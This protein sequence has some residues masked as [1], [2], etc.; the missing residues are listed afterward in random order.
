MK[1][2][3]SLLLALVLTLSV[4]SVAF[5]NETKKVTISIL[6]HWNTYNHALD[7]SDAPDYMKDYYD[8]IRHELLPGYEIEIEWILYEDDT[9]QIPLLLA[10]GDVP[11]IFVSD[12]TKFME[13]LDTG[14]FIEDLTPYLEQYGQNIL[15]NT[16]ARSRKI[17]TVGGKL[18]AIPSENFYYKFRTIIRTDWVEAL[19]FDVKKVYTLS[20]IKDIMLA[21]TNQDPDK[22]GKNDTFGLGTRYNGG[23]WPQSFMPIFGAFNGSI[24]DFYINEDN[25]V[26]SYN[27]S[28]DFRA[29]LSFLTEMYA[30]GAID[31]EVFVLNYD[32]AR[33][34]AAQGKGGMFSGWWNVVG[35][36]LDAGLLELQPEARLDFIYITS[37]DGKYEGNKDNGTIWK[38][39]M[40]S[41]D[42]EAPEAAIAIINFLHTQP[43]QEYGNSPILDENGQYTYEEGDE[44]TVFTMLYEHINWNK[45]AGTNDNDAKYNVGWRTA[46][47][48]NLF[49]NMTLRQDEQ[50]RMVVEHMPDGA[51]DPAVYN[52][53]EWKQTYR[54]YLNYCGD[55]MHDNPD[56]M[57][58]YTSVFYGLPINQ[59]AIDYAAGIE[60]HRTDWIVDFVTGVKDVN[61]D[62]QWAEYCKTAVDKGAQKVL[63]AYLATYNELNDTEIT[64]VQISK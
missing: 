5:A 23:D 21:M 7:M 24:D 31:P 14:Y 19:G 39:A 62:A 1:K 4:M 53:P 20:E 8:Y 61:D 38:T 52:T 34:K 47:F 12:G 48:D 36:L 41:K 32:Q 49:N 26:Y 50:N 64:A 9:A 45:F 13:Y 43:G 29:A 37:D 28:D 33:I 35:Q 51:D 54:N 58:V 16:E 18:P 11:D 44:K 56:D 17:C 60:T 30:A 63:D 25:E 3:L 57:G 27:Y 46:P 15:Q 6:G 40:I 42:C 22:N 10:S 59:A 55:M 2:M